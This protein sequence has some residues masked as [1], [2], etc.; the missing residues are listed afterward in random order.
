MKLHKHC[1]LLRH[2]KYLCSSSF[3]HK[4]I[5]FEQ[6]NQLL[7]STSEHTNFSCV[8]VIII[9]SWSNH[10]SWKL[11]NTGYRGLTVWIQNINCRWR[12]WRNKRNLAVNHFINIYIIH[13]KYTTLI[14][15]S[16]YISQHHRTSHSF[17][18]N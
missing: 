18:L 15:A 6:Y 13:L 11:P 12:L 1:Q 14:M 4:N 17:R 3:S 8:S 10:A 2:E 16:S 7:Y 9:M 5:F